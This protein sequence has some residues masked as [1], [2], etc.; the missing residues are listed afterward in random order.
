MVPPPKA[1]SA[2][3]RP[4]EVQEFGRGKG[5]FFF[6]EKGSEPAPATWGKKARKQKMAPMSMGRS[7]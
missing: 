3:G 4:R 6:A 1:M 7:P 2:T 5:L